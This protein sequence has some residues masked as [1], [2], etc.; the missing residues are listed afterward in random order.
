M[1]WRKSEDIPLGTQ[2]TAI[3]SP[4]TAGVGLERLAKIE[5]RLGGQGKVTAMEEPSTL[6]FSL[7]KQSLPLRN[8]SLPGSPENEFFSSFPL[9]TH[10]CISKSFL[11]A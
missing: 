5:R 2:D 1:L 9:D 7:P 10:T 11:V 8:N 3:I 4:Q 6:D